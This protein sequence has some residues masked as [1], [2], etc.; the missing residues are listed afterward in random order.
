MGTVDQKRRA[1]LATIVYKATISFVNK[2]IKTDTL[3]PRQWVRFGNQ[4]YAHTEFHWEKIHVGK[5]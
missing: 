5:R 2:K 3:S 1:S 4:K